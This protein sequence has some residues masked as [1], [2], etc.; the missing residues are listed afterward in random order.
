MIMDQL[1]SAVEA[2]RS[3]GRSIAKIK[4]ILAKLT[5]MD[6][7]NSNEFIQNTKIIIATDRRSLR[8]IYNL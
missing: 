6:L 3:T 7:M 8:S 1:C 2:G 4:I 5:R